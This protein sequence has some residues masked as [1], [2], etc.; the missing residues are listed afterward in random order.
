MPTSTSLPD[1]MDYL[2]RAVRDALVAAELG[3]AT[4]PPTPPVLYHGPEPDDCCPPQGGAPRIV[5]WWTNLGRPQGRGGD[6]ATPTQV[7][8]NV[9]YLCC[10]PNPPDGL[11]ANPA[12]IVR[13]YDADTRQLARVAW[14]GFQALSL[15]TGICTDGGRPAQRHNVAEGLGMASA[16]VSQARP[17]RPMGGC[18]GVDWTVTLVP[19]GAAVAQWMEPLVVTP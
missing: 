6:C 7:D 1:V 14:V 2:G 13:L 12:D 17:R 19:T 3:V 11:I 18:T 8:V 15:A 9:R 5:V 4:D 16:T 10:W